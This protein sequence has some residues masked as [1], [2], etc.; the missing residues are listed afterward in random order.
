MTE[1]S[2]IKRLIWYIDAILME[3][4]KFRKWSSQHKQDFDDLEKMHEECLPMHRNTLIDRK[5]QESHES[6][7]RRHQ[8]LHRGHREIEQHCEDLMAKL[9]NGKADSIDTAT[10]LANLSAIYEKI[11]NEHN[12]IQQERKQLLREHE[13]FHRNRSAQ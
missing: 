1:Q 7:L 5:I 12:H 3:E 10:E 2:P 4:R 9:R 13:R 6:M 8:S 11:R